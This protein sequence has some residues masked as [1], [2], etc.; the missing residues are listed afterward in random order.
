MK[1]VTKFYKKKQQLS[2]IN[3]KLKD[4][5]AEVDK[6]NLSAIRR[7]ELAEF[8]EDMEMLS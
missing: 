1:L 6:M 2:D 7:R 4:V 3:K 8:N 5:N